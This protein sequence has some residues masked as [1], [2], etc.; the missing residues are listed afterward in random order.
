MKKN[1]QI[2][3]DPPDISSERIQQHQD[4]DALLAKMEMTRPVQEQSK[5]KASRSWLWMVSAIAAALIGVIFWFNQDESL[6]DIRQQYVQEEAEFFEERAFISPPF[7][8]I[9]PTF[10]SY[11]VNARQGG[12]YTYGEASNLTVPTD[13]FQDENGVAVNGDVQLYYREMHDQA[14]FFLSGIPMTYDSAGV[15]Y[16][17]ESAGMIEIYAEQNGKRVLMRP[18]KSIDIELTST[19]NAPYLAIP[20]QYNIYRLNVADRK[21]EYQAQNKMSWLTSLETPSGQAASPQAQ[22]EQEKTAALAQLEQKYAAVTAPEKPRS[23]NTNQL[24]IELDFLDSFEGSESAKAIRKKYDGAIWQ[25]SERSTLDKA[26]AQKEWESVMVKDLGSE[27]YEITLSDATNQISFIVQ[28]ILPRADYEKA[29]AKYEEEL[30]RYEQLTATSEE[31]LATEKAALEERYAQRLADLEASDSFTNTSPSEKRRIVNTFKANQFGIWNCDRPLPPAPQE[32]VVTFKNAAGSVYENKRAYLMDYN[33]NSVQ[34]V[35][36]DETTVLNYDAN[37]RQLLWIVLEDNKIAVMQPEQF[38]DLKSE[39][40][41][42]VVLEVLEQPMDNE[43]D[44][45]RAIKI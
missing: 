16:V 39:E 9:Q 37:T 44:V 4:F 14:D 34:Q 11:T 15:N 6:T 25:L 24:S 3:F 27:E 5:P 23:R 28:P 10:A 35:F 43:Q 40:V 41:T 31:L 21:W 45:R 30:L 32:A 2:K 13:A 18:G 22:L 19:I 7:E 33:R 8:N 1:Y 29:I 12:S 36:I 26:E 42:E 38:Q 17:L 20:P